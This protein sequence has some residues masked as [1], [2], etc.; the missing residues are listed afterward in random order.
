M[1]TGQGAHLLPVLSPPTPSTPKVRAEFWK[2]AEETMLAPIKEKDPEL[3]SW[4]LEF[5]RRVI[6][7]VA[8]KD[9]YEEG[10]WDG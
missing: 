6:A 9:P 8:A 1:G 3:F 7:E 10:G 5:Q 2:W 4:I